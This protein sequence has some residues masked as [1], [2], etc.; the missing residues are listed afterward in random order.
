MSLCTSY[1]LFYL[2]KTTLICTFSRCYNCGEIGHHAKECN[3]PPLPK[4]CHHCKSVEHLVAQCPMVPTSGPRKTAE[5]VVA[6]NSMMTS[7]GQADA[8]QSSA[9]SSVEDQ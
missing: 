4:R 6:Q 5:Q 8:L 1:L 7:S 9:F 3:F 2:K